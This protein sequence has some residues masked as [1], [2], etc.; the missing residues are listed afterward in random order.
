MG[1]AEARCAEASRS[2]DSFQLSSKDTLQRDRTQK[3]AA[4]SRHFAKSEEALVHS[5]FAGWIG[6]AEKAR[7][8]QIR[9][10]RNLSVAQQSIANSDDAL[11]SL[12]LTS[13]ARELERA[14]YQRELDSAKAE[15]QR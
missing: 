6:L 13:W 15:Y 2:L 10:E 11:V 8:S 5:V 9:K 12:C 4:M 1:D 14:K 7:L 3:I